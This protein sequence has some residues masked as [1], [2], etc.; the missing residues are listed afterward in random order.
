[1]KNKGSLEERI[2]EWRDSL[3]RKQA[4]HSVDVVELEDHL[5]SQV[6]ALG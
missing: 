5:R 4:M 2:T 3:R 6:E 1:M